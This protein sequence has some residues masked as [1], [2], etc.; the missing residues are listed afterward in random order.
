MIIIYKDLIIEYIKRISLLS[1]YVG[2]KEIL[3][4]VGMVVIIE[5]YFFELDNVIFI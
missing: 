4:I 1:Y 2:D 5:E 3:I